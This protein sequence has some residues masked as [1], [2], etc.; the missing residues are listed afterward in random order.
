MDVNV[1]VVSGRLTR[2]MSIK[3]T[4]NGFTIGEFSIA[5]N[6]RE[7]KNGEWQ[8]AVSFFDCVMLGERAAKLQRYL[9][10][11]LS[12]VVAGELRQSRWEDKTARR[13]SKVE[14]IVDNVQFRAPAGS[15]ADSSG[16]GSFDDSDV[17]F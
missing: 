11:G 3:T 4:A 8:D 1:T 14:I 7:K 15:G 17:P 9:V 12:V 5:S 6:R 13:R 10:K 16:S 2:D